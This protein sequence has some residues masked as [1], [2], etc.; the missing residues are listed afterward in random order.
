MKVTSIV[1]PPKPV[2]PKITEINISLTPREAL[3]LAYLVGN[4][5]GE[6]AKNKINM[7]GWIAPNNHDDR[8]PDKLKGA[9]NLSESINITRLYTHI[10]RAFQKGI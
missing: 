4:M 9:A 3:L 10:M 5:N 6:E 7:G 1:E 8:F 2:V